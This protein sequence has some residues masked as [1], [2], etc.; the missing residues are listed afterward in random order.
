MSVFL[1]SAAQ[2]K[3]LKEIV[4]DMLADL[5]G[6]FVPETVNFDALLE[7]MFNLVA[8]EAPS[9]DVAAVIGPTAPKIAEH[10]RSLK[11][12][13]AIAAYIN[14]LAA[15]VTLIA[16]CASQ[17]DEPAGTTQ[18]IVVNTNT[19]NVA[20]ENASPPPAVPPPT[21]EPEPHIKPDS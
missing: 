13:E 17:H 16:A 14:L 1:S 12:R 11:S 21:S 18:Q 7:R 15:I 9:E 4:D 3:K 6:A 8:E 20:N 10:I 2:D 5:A 19:T